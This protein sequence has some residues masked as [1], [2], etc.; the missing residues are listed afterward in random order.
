MR[1]MS[2]ARF[3]QFTILS[4]LLTVALISPAAA[5]AT[6]EDAVGKA[7]SGGSCRLEQPRNPS[8]ARI[9]NT[10]ARARNHGSGTLVKQAGPGGI[11]L[12]CGHIFNEGAGSITVTF[13]DG[14][15]YPAELLDVDRQWDLAVLRIARPR[16]AAV[17]IASVA[18]RPGQWLMS[19]GYGRDGRYWC[20]RGQ[21]RGYVQAEGTRSFETLEI[22][23]MARQGDSGGPIFNERGEL[24]AVLWGTDGRVV[25]GTYCGRIRI[26][27]ARVF[28]GLSD[29]AAM[30]QRGGPQMPKPR[31]TRPQKVGP[32]NPGV[33]RPVVPVVRDGEKPAAL[34][35]FRK[36]LEKF[37]DALTLSDGLNRRIAD[38]L[39]DID[40]RGEDPGLREKA[41]E[42]ARQ[43]ARE[44]AKDVAGR[45]AEEF[46]AGRTDATAS[47]WVPGLVAG[48]GWTGPPAIAATLGI[49]LAGRLLR[50]RIG[51]KRGQGTEARGQG[52]TALNDSYAAQ[53]ADVFA[54][55]GHSPTADATLGREYDKELLQAAISSDGALAAWARSLRDR[56]AQRFYRIHDRQ[57]MPAEPVNEQ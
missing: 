53:L 28:G 10:T 9:V 20:N 6:G 40:S 11:I 22:S 18:P 2:L 35:R 42:A 48:L 34:E 13:P 51:K 47:S 16:A 39:K 45:V 50:R 33:Q 56:V 37:E 7:C 17:T 3:V 14:S 23:G 30:P 44:V 41:R 32:E 54:L 49:M 5:M 24:A 4:P 21:A 1:E 19:C 31:E 12:T 36:R 46:L 25:G 43:A 26:F 55:S 38:R 57:P 29:N 27:L 15:S 8:V 52:R